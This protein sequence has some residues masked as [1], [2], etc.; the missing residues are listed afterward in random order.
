MTDQ[1]SLKNALE[2]L[3]IDRKNDDPKPRRRRRILFLLPVILL[4]ALWV[5]FSGGAV[6]VT[7][8][9]AEEARVAEGQPVPV[10]NASG[11]VVARRQATVSSKITG[12]ITEISVEE[13][14]QVT[15]GQ[16]LARLDDSEMKKSLAL[17]EAQ[18]DAAKKAV[19]ENEVRL[20]QA[21]LELGRTEKLVAE[22]IRSQSDLDSGRAEVDSLEARLA[23]AR[24]EVEVAS[25]S[26]AV[27]RQL[28]ENTI[29]RAP[30]AGVAISK[31]AQPGEMISPVS[32]GGGFTRTGV[33]TIVDMS[34]LEI[35]V[36]VNENYIDRVRAGQQ[37][38]ARLNAYPDWKIPASVITTVPAAD[39]ESATVRVRIRFETLDPRIL[40]EMGAKVTFLSDPAEAGAAAK[41][42]SF[43]AA[44]LRKDGDDE[45]VF[46][47]KDGKAARRVV[48]V[49][50]RDG[51]RAIVAS[52]VA[53]G[54]V[55]IVVGPEK[56][57]EGR[58]VKSE[59]GR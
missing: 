20:A 31:N 29:I 43:P 19:R 21:R 52:G 11:Y 47:A 37:V 51:D 45:I 48:T 33:S 15:E 3:R 25:R 30:F 35:E 23:V 36:D 24:Q 16:I 46:L 14:L 54:D 57:A 8:A 7:T 22:Q 27:E 55:V 5:V 10:L 50:R 12:R 56:L 38:E 28:L 17:T 49:E 2:S 6:K 26:V 13:G 44:A 1:T 58:K 41:R 39:R 34:S 53:V 40:P 42:I 4:P 9:V 18:L 59:G 32:A